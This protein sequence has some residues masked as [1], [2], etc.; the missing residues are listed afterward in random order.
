MSLPSGSRLGPYEILSPLGA[1]GMGEV[2]RARDTR[3]DRVVAIKVLPGHLSSHPELRA[4][5]EREARAVSSLSHPNICALFDVGSQD[6]V[7]FLVMEHLEGETLAARLARGAMPA[8]EL[9]K[10]AIEIAGALDRAH[11]AG[12]VHRDLKPGNVMLTKAGAKLLD[13]GLAKSLTASGAGSDPALASL[14]AAPTGTSPLAGTSAGTVAAGS[15]PL[16]ARGTIIGTFQ[17]MAPEQFEAKE[18]DA[19]SDI[20]AFGAVLYEMATGRKAFEG[21]SQATLIAAILKDEPRPLAEIAPI[22]PAGLDRLVRTC[23]AKDPDERRQSVHDILIELRWIAEG[24]A[25]AGPAASGARAPDA[26]A[27]ARSRAGRG[28]AGWIAAGALGLAAI[29]GWTI[30]LRATRVATNPPQ[31][32][33]F[34]VT[35]PGRSIYGSPASS[36]REFQISPDGRVLAFMAAD[37]AGHSMIFVRPLDDFTAR[38]LAGTESAHSLIWSPDSRFLAFEQEHR[39]KKISLAGGVPETLCDTDER[40]QGG[41]WGKGGVILFSVARSGLWRVPET[42]GTPSIV[43]R[44]DAERNERGHSSPVFLPD[45]RRFM[46]RT[47]TPKL[48]DRAILA[49]S[50]DSEVSRKVLANPFRFSLL[51]SGHLLFVR[52]ASL[53]AQ[54]MDLGTLELTG[55]PVV[56][57]DSIALAA[58]PGIAAFSAS[59]NGVIAY[60]AA[61]ASRES[62]LVWLDR[63]GKQLSSIGSPAADVSVSLSPDGTRAAVARSG[64]NSAFSAGGEPPTNLWVIDLVRD[65]GTRVTLDAADSDENVVWSADGSKLVFARHVRGASAE[66]FEKPASGAGAETRLLESIV[67]LHPIDWSS[68]GR[69]LLLHSSDEEGSMGIQAASLT[70]D[71]VIRPF[72]ATPNNEYLAQFSPDAR[73]VAYASDESG[74]SEIYVQTFPPGESRWQISPGGGGDPRWRKDGHEIFYLAPDGTMMS[75]AVTLAPA[76]RATAPVPLFPTRLRPTEVWFYGTMSLYDVAPDG[77]RFLVANPLSERATEPINVI[78]GWRPPEAK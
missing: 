14:T 18:A 41:A 19:R 43:T 51:D 74:R 34:P 11:R 58:V 4:R 38:P 64:A 21:K 12:I 72:L 75:A 2:Y 50:L 42:G 78:V 22:A 13:F 17:Y 68:D 62:Q 40:T 36:G 24:G 63:S 7:D 39:L 8:P 28:L 45:G 31:E 77:Q 15:A 37:P 76:F 66:V 20:F 9:L 47:M 54:K 32:I 26:S 25:P 65:I 55:E 3:L 53:V 30:A 29:A 60:A 49:G 52:G 73:F 10:T 71:H 57:V 61:T 16:T 67:N 69:W 59:R 46:Y 35:I 56:V 23:L 48:E 27:A 5:F 33:R 44:L 6:G 1:G 70:G